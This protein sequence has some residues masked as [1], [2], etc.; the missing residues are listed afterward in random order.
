M[1]GVCYRALSNWLSV[2][3]MGCGNCEMRFKLIGVM[4][5]CLQDGFEVY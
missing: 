3:I 4:R 2:D 5:L 1:G